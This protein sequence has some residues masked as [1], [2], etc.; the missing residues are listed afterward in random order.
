MLTKKLI[1]DVKKIEI[2]TRRIVDELT[3]GAYHSVFKGRGLEF[4]EVREYTVDD[5]VRDIDWNVTARMG[6]PYIKKFTEERELSVMLLIDAS[7]STVFG[8]GDKT[9]RQQVVKQNASR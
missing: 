6:R 2:K 7:A 9:K 4:S 1:S 5:D 8:S 3:A